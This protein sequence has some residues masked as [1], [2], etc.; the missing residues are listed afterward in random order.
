MFDTLTV[1]VPSMDDG[2]DIYHKVLQEVNFTEPRFLRFY[3]MWSI[4][5]QTFEIIKE[6][7]AYAPLFYDETLNLFTSRYILFTKLKSH[8]LFQELMLNI[9]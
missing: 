5:T 6:I 4:N 8:K 3:E 7:I 9:N 2:N 1:V